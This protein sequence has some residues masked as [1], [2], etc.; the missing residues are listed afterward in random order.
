MKCF[1]CERELPWLTTDHIVPKALGGANIPKNKIKSCF[2]CNQLKGPLM[3][4]EFI[5]K[6][7]N[8]LKDTP[9][10][11][12]YERLKTIRK[13]TIKLDKYVKSSIVNLVRS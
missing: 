7:D 8:L 11:H 6:I 4:S 3:P 12:E 9:F 13:N 2:K 1:Y 10:G 5:V